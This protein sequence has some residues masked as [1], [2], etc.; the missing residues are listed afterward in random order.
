MPFFRTIFAVAAI[1]LALVGCAAT[2]APMGAQRGTPRLESD[3]FVTRDGLRLPL[4]HWDA[5]GPPR[6]IIVAL[7][8]MSDYSNAFDGPGKQWAAAGITTLAFDQRG[9]G[10]GPD[11]GLWAG[12]VAMRT[13]LFDIVIA[14]KTRYPGVPVFALG[15]SMGGAVLL[16]ALAEPDPPPVAGAILVAPAV[17]AR[18]D[19]P[20][21]YRVA[22]FF[23]AHLAPGLILS[24]SAASH[25]VTIVPSDN[26]PMLRALGR[27]P[28]FQKHTRAD[29][30]FGL[31]NLMDEARAAPDKLETPPPILLLT[32]NKDQVIPHDATN[33]VVATLGSRATVRRYDQGYH[34]LLRDLEGPAV[35]KDVADWVLAR[36]GV[37]V[38]QPN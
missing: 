24:N 22:L 4:R 26:I 7:H 21:S 18:S 33:G 29:A 19:M 38:M 11:P 5:Q 9:F 34:M 8:G 6:A 16:S 1:S 10:S 30:L 23:A 27:D 12:G 37:A 20:L 35:N 36:P 28:L 25:V 3:V 13:D 14:A 17:W 32:G 15:E 31:V 2:P